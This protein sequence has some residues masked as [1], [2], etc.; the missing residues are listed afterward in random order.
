MYDFTGYE[1][2]AYQKTLETTRARYMVFSVLLVALAT[3]LS[4]LYYMRRRKQKS[5]ERIRQINQ[6]YTQALNKYGELHAELENLKENRS[7]LLENK[8]NEIKKLRQ[9]LAST[10]EDRLSPEKWNIENAILSNPIIQAMHKYAETGDAPESLWQ[11]FEGYLHQTIP[12]FL[13]HISQPSYRLSEVEHKVC[14]LIRLR[15]LPSETAN[16]LKLSSQRLTNI[17]TH[18]N[19]KLFNARGTKGLDTQIRKIPA[20]SE[21][22]PC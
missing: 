11:D 9:I 7:L 1:K 15:F 10:Q 8:Q 5:Q 6:Q 12:Q 21:K 22:N 18:I 20:F 14:L 17:R 2:L 4:L 19:Q 13:L 3:I 16:L